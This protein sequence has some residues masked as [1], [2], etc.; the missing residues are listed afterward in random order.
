MDIYGWYGYRSRKNQWQRAAGFLFP[1]WCFLFPG[2]FFF[3]EGWFLFPHSLVFFVPAMGVKRSWNG[4]LCARRRFSVPD[5]CFSFPVELGRPRVFF[6][7][8]GC[9]QAGGCWSDKVEAID[10]QRGLAIK[11]Q[12]RWMLWQP[13]PLQEQHEYQEQHEDQ[14]QQHK[15]KGKKTPA[16]FSL[17][18][19]ASSCSHTPSKNNMNNNTRRRKNT[20][21]HP[22]RTTNAY[23]DKNS[24]QK[25]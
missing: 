12:V 20:Q 18:K 25:P 9:S 23:K 8:V 19:L 5:G 4:V 13:H 11:S 7:P 15:E 14:I 1:E 2:C 21:E 16:C 3:P 24:T 17:L 22:T 6:V 10:L